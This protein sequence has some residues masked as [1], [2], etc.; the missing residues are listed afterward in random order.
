SDTSKCGNCIVDEGEDCDCG[1]FGCITHTCCDNK[2]CKFRSGA[3]C[4]SGS[5]CDLKSC[6]PAASN[7]ICRMENSS[8]DLPEYCDGVNIDCPI[9]LH[10]ADGAKCPNDKDSICHGG[11]CGSRKLQCAEIWGE[12]AIPADKKCYESN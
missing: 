2:T 5:C 9:D 12:K 10:L 11:R 6:S 8:C 3:K 1:P 4:A 7:R